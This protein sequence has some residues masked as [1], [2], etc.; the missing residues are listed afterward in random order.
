MK[1]RPIG[2]TGMLTS[3]LS[4]GFWATYGVK[5]E[6]KD[7]AG[8]EHAKELLTIARKAGVNLYD[9]AEVY[10]ETVG[11]AETIMGEAIA[12]LSKEDPE[13]WRRSDILVTTKIFWGGKGLNEKGLSRKHIQEGLTKSLERLQM[14]E[15]DRLWLSLAN[16][17]SLDYCTLV[18][19]LE[20]GK[21]VH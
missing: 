9:N 21:P 14:G 20:E 12:Q 19:T 2:N 1:H 15:W 13:L 3:V 8:V 16:F 18:S 10:G 4:F 5:D 11:D 17:S 6:L 7:S